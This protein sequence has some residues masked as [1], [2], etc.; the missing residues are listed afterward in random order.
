MWLFTHGKELAVQQKSSTSAILAIIAAAGSYFM[1]FSARPFWGML[2]ALI[3]IPLGILGL[4][5]AASPRVGGGL[6]SLIAMI[7]GV[8]AMGLAVLVM[9]GVLIF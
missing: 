1:S 7:L 2:A 3:S 4:V 8:F 6:L 9:I 5:R